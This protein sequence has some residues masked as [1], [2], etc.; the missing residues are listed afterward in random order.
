DV[1]AQHPSRTIVLEHCD[2]DAR[3]ASLA[4]GVGIVTFGPAAARYGVEHIVVR[5]RC[6]ERPLL[7]ILRRVVRGDVPTSVWWTEDLSEGAPFDPLLTVGRQLVYDSRGW[8]DARRGFDA[9]M[10]LLDNH[11]IDLA[12]LN[13]RRLAALRR[14]LI[15]VRGPLKGD[16]W[17]HPVTIAHGDGEA[18]V[19]LLLAGWIRSG[20]REGAP[21]VEVKAAGAGDDA[22][23]TLTIA[24]STATFST[25]AVEILSPPSPPLVVAVPNEAQADAVAAELRSLS[26][27]PVFLAALR[28]LR[29]TG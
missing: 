17:R 27:D 23:L 10:P 4:A 11:R 21:E 19:A 9:L 18:A 26:P 25:R 20:R 6:A 13:W 5:S 29:R 14:A 7:S 28:A 24:Q 3:H 8:S 1:A 22:I 2:D 15:H 16:A 12:D